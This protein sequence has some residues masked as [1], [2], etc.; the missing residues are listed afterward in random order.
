MAELSI[1]SNMLYA[2]TA[3]IIYAICIVK[4]PI[5]I[6]F[7]SEGAEGAEGEEYVKKEFYLVIFVIPAKAGILAFVVTNNTNLAVGQLRNQ[8]GKTNSGG[9]LELQY[10]HKTL[11]P[12]KKFGI[13][14]KPQQAQGE[15]KSDKNYITPVAG[16]FHQQQNP[17]SSLLWEL[18]V[19]P[20][21]L[22]AADKA[23]EF[24]RLLVMSPTVL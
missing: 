13:S 6:F 24:N 15:R 4:T 18:F 20:A 10:L 19:I 11:R 9:K 17:D 12:R 3:N 1:Q 7:T 21:C 14:A 8:S 16:V 2:Y 5:N 23:P 22:R